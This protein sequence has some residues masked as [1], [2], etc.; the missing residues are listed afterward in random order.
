MGQWWQGLEV[1]EKVFWIITVPATTFMLL[2]TLM[3]F[4]GMGDDLDADVEADIDF[5]DVSD[6][7]PNGFDISWSIFTVRNMVAFFTFFGW[8]GIVLNQH[9]TS[10]LVVVTLAIVAG[11]LATMISLSFFYLMQ[12]MTNDGSVKPTRS[13]GR[14]GIVYIPVPANQSGIGKISLILSGGTRELEAMTTSDEALTTNT[15]VK[16]VG[17]AEG[18]VVLVVEDKED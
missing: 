13:I 10:K 14:K 11:L 15:P 16:V 6:V 7:N 4:L 12:K 8:T 17:M 3:T 2:Q 5:G 1:F 18:N 9:M